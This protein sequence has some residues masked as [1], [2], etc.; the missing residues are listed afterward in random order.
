[1]PSPRQRSTRVVVAVLAILLATLMP[2]PVE[3]AA[4]LVSPSGAGTVVI[5]PQAME[6]NLQIHPGDSLRAGLRPLPA[7]TQQVQNRS[8]EAL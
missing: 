7:L 2:P 1:M 5:G 8:P 3:A 4:P 6:G